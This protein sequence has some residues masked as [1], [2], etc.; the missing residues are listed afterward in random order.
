MKK[1]PEGYEFKRS[2]YGNGRRRH[3][4]R[5]YKWVTLCGRLSFS[6]TLTEGGVM[7][8]SCVRRMKKEKT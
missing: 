5:Q 7:C 2:P 4:A 1:L 6:Y 8:P 3:I